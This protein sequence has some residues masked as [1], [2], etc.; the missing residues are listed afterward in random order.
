MLNSNK[1][2]FWVQTQCHYVYFWLLGFFDKFYKLHIFDRKT[3]DIPYWEHKKIEI[4][5]SYGFMWM[6]YN[7]VRPPLLKW[8]YH[9]LKIVW[10]VFS[11]STCLYYLF[12]RNTIFYSEFHLWEW[13]SRKKQFAYRLLWLIFWNR[14]FVFMTK[15]AY[16]TFAPITNKR[17]Y[18][19]YLYQ[20][21]L[22]PNPTLT[23]ETL[24][25]LFVGKLWDKRKNVKFMMDAL[26]TLKDKNIQIG[27]AW[28]MNSIN[29]DFPPS[30]EYFDF[31][32]A[33]EDYKKVFWDKL[34]YHGFVSHDTIH[35]LYTQYN[36]FVLP[37]K[38]ESIWAVI[39][40]AMAHSMPVLVSHT[41]GAADYVTHG[42]DGFIFEL[43]NREEFLEK[44]NHFIQNPS[45]KEIMGK[46][47]H[48]TIKEKYWFK[49]MK[50]L[51]SLH[52]DFKIFLNQ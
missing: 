18:F 21:E 41:V 28:N 4:L 9:W 50:L 49:N 43:D 35:E 15:R 23:D 32:D 20:W 17:L 33:F 2:L 31:T 25:I 26:M 19:P 5:H 29:P 42:S 37:S 8:K 1:E 40:E 34:Q 24:K 38:F 48:D 7:R 12:G 10:D 47:A 46:K 22:Y 52:N 13:S 51:K 36:L 30:S 16:K 45:L 6:F 14:K 11:N 27:L 3:I 44:I 39:P